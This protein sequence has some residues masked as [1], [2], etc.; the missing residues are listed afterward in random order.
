[1]FA[2]PFPARRQELI[3]LIVAYQTICDY[4]DNLCDRCGCTDGRAFKQ[5]HLALIDALTPGQDYADYYKYYPYKDDSGYLNKLVDECRC[6]LNSLP[7]WGVVQEESLQLAELYCNLQIYKH[8]M[9]EIREETLKEWVAAE[10]KAFPCLYWQEFAAAC[11]STLAV[12]NLMGLAS[13]DELHID[14]VRANLK[15]YF[16]WICSLH[17]LLDYFIDRQEDTAG[18]DLNFTFYY[19]NS[20]EV[21]NRLKLLVRQSH[22]SISGLP[23]SAFPKTVIEGLLAMYLSDRKIKEQGLD[24]AARELLAESGPP[25]LRTYRICKIVRKFM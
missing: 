12:F 10:S 20:D 19:E 3:T 22:R 23:E 7:S 8:L 18:G 14:E 5:L 15:A 4:L 2:L 16:P 13:K 21:I 11:G 25:A 1:M 17:I 24:R 6:C 9:V